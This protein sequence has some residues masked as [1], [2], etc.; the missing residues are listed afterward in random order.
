[1]GDFVIAAH[2][3]QRRSF[4]MTFYASRYPRD[5]PTLHIV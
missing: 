5:V 1:L 2:A 3:L 4:L